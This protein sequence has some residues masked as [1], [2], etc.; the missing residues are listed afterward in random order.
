MKKI[1]IISDTHNN[2]RLL[3]TVLEKEA[4]SDFVFHLGDYY[5]DMDSNFDLTENKILYRVPG[6]NQKYFDQ[7]I[8]NI[9]KIEIENWSFSF[10][11]TK[12]DLFKQNYQTDFY[13]YG[14]SHK[15]EFVTRNN[16]FYLNPGHLKS[17]TDRGYEA[18]YCVLDLDGNNLL[19]KF[20]NLEGNIFFRKSL[21]KRN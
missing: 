9:L 12:N 7:R 3:R 21:Y 20:F 17:E 10:A 6:L 5:E 16:R 13:L 18:T 15:K 4:D 14:H 11:H 19:V 1:L 2:Q 8:P